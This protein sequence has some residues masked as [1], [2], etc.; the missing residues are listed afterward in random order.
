MGR[1]EGE[2]T[3]GLYLLTLE[4]AEGEATQGLHLIIIGGAEAGV[5][6]GRTRQGTTLRLMVKNCHQLDLVTAAV[7]GGAP[8]RWSELN[9]MVVAP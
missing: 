5:T 8:H 9:A 6:V 2:A 1:F 3:Q 4:G 7:L